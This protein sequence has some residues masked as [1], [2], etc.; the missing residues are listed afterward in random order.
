MQKATQ[1]DT[2]EYIGAMLSH[3]VSMA[4]ENRFPTLGY[5]LNLAREEAMTLASNPAPP[6]TKE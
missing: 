1:R 2:A 5:L 6:D 3:L 4:S